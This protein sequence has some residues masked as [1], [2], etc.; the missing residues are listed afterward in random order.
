MGFFTE[1]CPNCGKSVHKNADYCRHCGCQKSDSW[2]NC[3]RCNAAVAGDSKFCWKC[4]NEQSAEVRRQIYGDRWHRSPTDFAVRIELAHPEQTLHGGLQIDDGTVALLFQEGKFHGLLE[5]GHH[6]FDGFLRRLVGFHRTRQAHA[7]L[8]DARTAEIDF[9]LESIRTR[10][11]DPVDVRLR[12]LFEVGEPR[13]FAE[14]LLQT[15]ETFS[16][17]DLQRAFLG[18]VREGMQEILASKTLEEVM[19]EVRTR[20][21][22]ERELIARLEPTLTGYGMKVVGVRLADFAGP[23]LESLREKRGEAEHLHRE[24]ELNR[25]LSDLTRAGKVEAFRDE[26][27]LED[28]HKAILHQF[29]LKNTD[30]AEERQRLVQA[31]ESRA[32]L[33]AMHREYES[34]LAEIGH[35]MEEQLLRHRSELL[36]VEQGVVKDRVRFIWELERRKGEF[37]IRQEEMRVQAVT[38]LEVARQG[39]EALKLVQ[40]AKFEEAQRKAKSDLEI[41]GERLRLRQN[42]SLQALL[43]LVTPEQGT[44]LLKLA[45]LEMRKGLGV[46]QSLA[47][48]AEKNPEIAPAIAKAL[49]AKYRSA[50]SSGAAS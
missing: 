45:E 46:E 33:E 24:M 16:T 13:K 21:L 9:Q 32:S 25:Q 23:A 2:H 4:G 1:R 14:R 44:Q 50:S 5:P 19:C 7:I 49:E 11:Q 28:E 20:D 22:V 27:T 37:E 3:V 48:V 42:V 38:E 30:R 29:G 31:L 39:V 10:Q 26:K 8:L 47:L 41:E 18:D 15:A 17:A 36:D 43:T 34:R 6:T 12:L 35:R 40:A